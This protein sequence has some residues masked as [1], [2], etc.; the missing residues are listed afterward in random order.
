MTLPDERLRSLKQAEQLLRDLCDP[1]TT[2]RIPRTLRDRARGCLRHY[3]TD[4]DLARA[5][6]A[7]PDVFSPDIEAVTRLFMR[8]AIN[9]QAQENNNE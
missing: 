5:A 8:H 1:R 7:A 9:K 4:Y 3:P 6:E 2:P